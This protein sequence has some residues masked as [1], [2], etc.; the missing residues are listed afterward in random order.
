MDLERKHND[1]VREVSISDG[2]LFV[3]LLSGLR[4]SGPLMSDDEFRKLASNPRMIVSGS[5][6]LGGGAPTFG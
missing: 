5:E 4:L 1:K 2:C 6:A 3:E